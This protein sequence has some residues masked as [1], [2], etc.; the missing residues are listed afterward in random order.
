MSAQPGGGNGAVERWRRERLD[1]DRER[2]PPRRERFRTLSGL[3][4][5]DLYTPADVADL[6]YERDIGYPGEYPFTRGV[7]ATH[8]PRAARGRSARSRASGAPRT[9]TRATST[10]SSTARPASRPTST[11]RRC[12]ATTPTTRCS[13]ARSGKIGVAIDTVVDAH[14]LFDGIPLD[15]VST[16]LTITAPAA[17]LIAMYRV[18]GEERGMPGDV[19]TGHRSERHPQGVHGPERVHLPARALGR[20][21]RGHDGVLR[22]RRCRGSTRSASAATT[23]AR[24]GSTAV[25]ELALTLAAGLTYLERASGARDRRRLGRPRGSRSSSTSTTTCSRRWRSS[26][27]PGGC[28]RG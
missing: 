18:V 10:C 6:D 5:D 17:V 3:A 24:P 19:L 9:R 21:R 22:A 13:R 27:P 15:R 4:I 25:E 7:H 26:A 20:A 28:G 12:S 16:S 14:A 11:C 8:V 1:P 23:S 2:V